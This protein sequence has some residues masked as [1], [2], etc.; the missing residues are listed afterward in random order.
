MT[1]DGM[2][3]KGLTLLNRLSLSATKTDKFAVMNGKTAVKTNTVSF[4]KHL[5]KALLSSPKEK[6]EETSENNLLSIKDRLGAVEA[7][8]GKITESLEKTKESDKENEEPI[9]VRVIQL[10]KGSVQLDEEGKI[11]VSFDQLPNSIKE[12]LKSLDITENKLHLVE[13]KESNPEQKNKQADYSASMETIRSTKEPSESKQELVLE[14]IGGEKSQNPNGAVSDIDKKQVKKEKEETSTA[15]SLKR[16]VRDKAESVK[17]S[18]PQVQENILQHSPNDSKIAVLLKNEFNQAPINNNTGEK[19]AVNEHLNGILKGKESVIESLNGNREKKESNIER[20]IGNSEKKKASL[21]SF[22]NNQD[23]ATTAASE[24]KAAKSAFLS[25]LMAESGAS[26]KGDLIRTAANQKVV[27]VEPDSKKDKVTTLAKETAAVANKAERNGITSKKN[28]TIAGEANSAFMKNLTSQRNDELPADEIESKNL[29]GK[30]RLVSQTD[31]KAKTENAKPHGEAEEKAKP[32][33][34]K[35]GLSAGLLVQDSAQAAH[36]ANRAEDGKTDAT[37]EKKAAREFVKSFSDSEPLRSKKDAENAES[38]HRINK[39]ENTESPH[40]IMKEAEIHRETAAAPAQEYAAARDAVAYAAP[41]VEEAAPAKEDHGRTNVVLFAVDAEDASALMGGKSQKVTLAAEAGDSEDSFGQ[42]ENNSK[43]TSTMNLKRDIE[44]DLGSVKI[45]EAVDALGESKV[46]EE[47]Q[48]AFVESLKKNHI[49]SAVGKPVEQKAET[50]REQIKQHFERVILENWNDSQIAAAPPKPAAALEA[51]AANQAQTA[52]SAPAHTA[53]AASAAAPAAEAAAPSMAKEYAEQIAK[54]QDA[55]SQQIVRA[56][57]G[58]MGSERSHIRLQLEPESLGRVHIQLKMESGALTAHIMAMK[59]ETRAMLE[60][61]I[62]FLRT[63]FDDQ[64]I[65]VER[66]VVAKEDAN[67]RHENAREEDHS[68]PRGETSGRN[69]GTKQQ[70]R[71]T[72][73]WS[74]RYSSQEYF[75]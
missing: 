7:I 35:D 20:P 13:E 5:Q 55:A 46:T 50:T 65:K 11:K 6:T 62:S 43:Q 61:N 72:S 8:Q 58:S 29:K 16:E 57:Q 74:G 32:S 64:G 27:A 14:K 66:L 22:K 1:T 36:K 70:K 34:P 52:Q 56:V 53:Q 71:G 67:G 18:I 60:Q 51:P 24:T 2:M 17:Q 25:K 41:L 19:V 28:D 12:Q 69:G 63:A 10:P 9:F 68:R 44:T 30:D 38:P 42:A 39:E 4:E 40:R 37:V 33:S 45:K 59:P 23:K 47:K 21:E 15:F 31:S 3:E 26:S 49:E 48:P 75:V 73:S 54:M